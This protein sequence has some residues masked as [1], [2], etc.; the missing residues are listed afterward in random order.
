M[1][2]DELLTNGR[3]GK[4]I[5]EKGPKLRESIYSS[6]RVFGGNGTV[7]EWFVFMNEVIQKQLAR[8]LRVIS[9]KWLEKY[10][11]AMFISY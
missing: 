11:L 4:R 5:V 8:S 1:R 10:S 6:V 3:G 9:F 7:F 2:M